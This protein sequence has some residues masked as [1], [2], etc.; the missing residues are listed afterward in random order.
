VN[1]EAMTVLKTRGGFHLLVE[2]AK[3]DKQ[4]VKTWYPRLTGI[5]GVDIK[6]DNLVPVPGCCQG[7]FVPH[8]SAF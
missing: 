4:L 7:G 6:G 5:A 8:F 2:L 1:K 3:I